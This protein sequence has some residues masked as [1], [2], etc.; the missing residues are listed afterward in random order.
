MEQW[1]Y[2]DW[3]NNRIKP[4]YWEE[5]NKPHSLHYTLATAFPK[6]LSQEAWEAIMQSQ[7]ETWEE[8]LTMNLN[9][10]IKYIND[11][12]KY[13]LVS[14]KD[15]FLDLERKII[16]KE[17]DSNLKAYRDVLKDYRLEINNITGADFN[18][19]KSYKK[20]PPQQEIRLNIPDEDWLNFNMHLAKRKL[21]Y[22]D[23][24]GKD[25]GELFEDLY[26]EHYI[27][28]CSLSDFN[29]V[30]NEHSIP[31]GKNKIK[32]IGPRY[33]GFWFGKY[34]GMDVKTLN[35]LLEPAKGGPFRNNDNTPLKNEAENLL[36]KHFPKN[37]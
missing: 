11:H 7:G 13:E 25:W 29:F 9:V 10:W 15:Q 32:W 33:I 1:T 36:L 6:R 23:G 8:A 20:Y 30:M 28:D 31:R 18:Q 37:K 12:L 35:E 34:A 3:L 14:N 5:G 4:E 16:Q 22:L 17:I 27:A 2:D 21:E 24:T 19:I 26:N